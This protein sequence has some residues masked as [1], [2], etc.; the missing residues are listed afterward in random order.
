[1][2]GH[3]GGVGAVLVNVAPTALL[4]AADGFIVAGRLR[5]AILNLNGMFPEPQK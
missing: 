2:Q 5:H 4:E 1:M 3:H